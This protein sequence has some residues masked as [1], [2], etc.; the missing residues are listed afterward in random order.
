MLEFLTY[1]ID[2]KSFETCVC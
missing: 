1:I 2:Q